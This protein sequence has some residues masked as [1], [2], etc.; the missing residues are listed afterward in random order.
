MKPTH[1]TIE[2]IYQRLKKY[3][4][5]GGNLFSLHKWTILGWYKW[6]NLPSTY[7]SLRGH[8]ITIWGSHGHNNK[9][10]GA[11]PMGHIIKIW[12]LHGHTNN[13]NGATQTIKIRGYTSI[14]GT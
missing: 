2:I 13:N 14:L 9:N 7:R 12:G 5:Q 10:N 11:T 1:R 8:I 4:L 6:Q 3:P